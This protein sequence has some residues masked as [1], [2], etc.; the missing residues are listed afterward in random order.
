MTYTFVENKNITKQ[1]ML[2]M[3]NVGLHIC[4]TVPSMFSTVPS[5]E[6]HKNY[7]K[8]ALGIVS[9]IHDGILSKVLSVC[10]LK[11]EDQCVV[12]NYML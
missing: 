8:E 1:V 9:S 5:I 2:Y 3:Q 7:H 11:V 4:N 10:L 12:Y 6:L